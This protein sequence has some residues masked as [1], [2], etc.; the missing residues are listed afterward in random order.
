SGFPR[1]DS[2]AAARLAQP[3]AFLPQLSRVHSHEL[4][5]ITTALVS[6]ASETK[7]WSTSRRAGV[8]SVAQ[9]PYEEREPGA[10]NDGGLSWRGDNGHPNQRNAPRR[11]EPDSN[12]CDYAEWLRLESWARGRASRGK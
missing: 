5:I 4:S 11:V 6:G 3:H 2:I 9:L 7:R 10:G 12:P 8:V 1:H